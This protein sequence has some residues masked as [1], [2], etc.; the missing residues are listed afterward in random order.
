MS[1]KVLVAE[2]NLRLAELLAEVLYR[3]GAEVTIS[4][5]PAVLKRWIA[6]ATGPIVLDGSVMRQAGYTVKSLPCWA[7]IFSGDDD[8][9]AEARQAG[10]RAFL[11]GDYS[12]VKELERAVFEQAG[13]RRA[14]S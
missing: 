13:E 10:L 5:E 14:V 8:L 2:D 9:V 11:K 7:V 1:C 3:G 6:K 4:D 12:S